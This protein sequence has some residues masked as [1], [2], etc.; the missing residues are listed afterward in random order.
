MWIVFTEYTSVPR[1]LTVGVGQFQ[2]MLPSFMGTGTSLMQSLTETVMRLQMTLLGLLWTRDGATALTIAKVGNSTN[3]FWMHN[4]PRHGVLQ[5]LIPKIKMNIIELF[6]KYLLP[7][8]GNL[9]PPLPPPPH[10]MLTSYCS[11][12]ALTLPMWYCTHFSIPPKINF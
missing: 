4:R 1:E 9:R 11:H 2:M 3:Y 12:L 8:S 10:P 6:I 7:F 5:Q